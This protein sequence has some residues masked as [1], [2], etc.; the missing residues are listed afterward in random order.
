MSVLKHFLER[1]LKERNSILTRSG[2][3]SE[4]ISEMKMPFSRRWS[5]PYLNGH[6]FQSRVVFFCLLM[7][8]ENIVM[9]VEVMLG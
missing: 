4:Y 3:G 2:N 7:D 6:R 1:S 8:F 9:L 5:E